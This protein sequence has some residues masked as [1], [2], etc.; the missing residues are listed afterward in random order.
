MGKNSQKRNI[1][2]WLNQTDIPLSVISKKSKVSRAT[3]YN[4]KTNSTK[5]GNKG[6]I[7]ITDVFEDEIYIATKNINVEDDVKI[8]YKKEGEGL[9]AQYIID[10]QKD[11]I[12]SLKEKISI[13][14]KQKM[15]Y[16]PIITTSL[17]DSIDYDFQT[18]QTYDS[19]DFGYF[20]SYKIIRWQD[21]FAK[22]GYYGEEAKI[23]HQK[24]LD[25]MDYKNKNTDKA[26]DANFLIHRNVT[27]EE[28]YNR[29]ATNQFFRDEKSAQTVSKMTR[30]NLNYRHKN[31]SYVPAI[32]HCLFDFDKLTGISKIKFAH[33]NNN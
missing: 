13:L 6:A 23:M 24:H 4:W 20:K 31:G 16:S 21:F 9:E 11:K 22:L 17:W 19:R 7:K 18:F 14:E 28:L 3:L 29:D 10:L 1:L 32:L 26:N 30:F 33:T 15:S 12:E 27:D 5:V 2:L 8:K 25:S